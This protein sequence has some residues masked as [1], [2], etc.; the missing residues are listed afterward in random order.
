M[1][2]K[3]QIYT[4]IDKHVTSYKPKLVG[5]Q[6][7]ASLV[8]QMVKNLPAMQET[9]VWS[10]D[11]EDP[12]EE[13]LATHSSILAWRIPWTEEP[14]GLQSVG[15]QRAGHNWV[16]NTHT[17]THTHTQ[18]LTVQYRGGLLKHKMLTHKHTW[19]CLKWFF[20]GWSEDRCWVAKGRLCWSTLISYHY[21]NCFPFCC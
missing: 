6:S 5:L 20:H 10:L 16:T 4:L 21:L 15:W 9:W 13:G 8:A 19:I 3:T 17:H 14:G 18:I 2:C 7:W 12:M 1:K 11:W